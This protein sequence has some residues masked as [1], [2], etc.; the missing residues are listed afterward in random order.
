[1]TS[2]DILKSLSVEGSKF[3]VVDELWREVTATFS[4]E[5][6]IRDI[7]RNKKIVPCLKLCHAHLEVVQKGLN[8]YLEAKRL[9]FPRFFFLSN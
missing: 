5:L 3:K 4:K 6:L 9:N 8:S 7:T 1:M 2:P